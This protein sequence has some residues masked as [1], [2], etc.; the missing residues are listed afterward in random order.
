M[1]CISNSSV[2]GLH[3]RNPITFTLQVHD[4]LSLALALL[5]MS[6]TTSGPLRNVYPIILFCMESSDLS[7]NRSTVGPEFLDQMISAGGLL[8]K[9][10]PQT[11]DTLSPKSA[12]YSVRLLKVMLSPSDSEKEIH[13]KIIP[14]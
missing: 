4:P 9:S 13:N 3:R 1:S 12:T 5:I 8:S 2:Q 6:F 14:L 10:V 11:R 7:T